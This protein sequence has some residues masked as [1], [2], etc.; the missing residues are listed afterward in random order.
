MLAYFLSRTSCP[1]T[2]TVLQTNRM[3]VA[4]HKNTSD[5]AFVGLF[6]QSRKCSFT[7]QASWFS[8]PSLWHSTEVSRTDDQPENA[9]RHCQRNRLNWPHPLPRLS[10]VSSELAATARHCHHY[11]DLSWGPYSLSSL[12]TSLCFVT[13][14]L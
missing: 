14:L 6:L 7:K 3:T 1:G 9:C 10:P 12:W 5:F 2:D 11:A 8:V 4:A 13:L